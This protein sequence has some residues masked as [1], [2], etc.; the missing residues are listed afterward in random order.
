MSRNINQAIDNLIKKVLDKVD[1]PRIKEQK[2]TIY[3]DEDSKSWLKNLKTLQKLRLFP[4]FHSALGDYNND[5]Y[6]VL[7]NHQFEKIPCGLREENLNS[8]SWV[9]IIDDLN[10]Q[11]TDNDVSLLYEF[12]DSDFKINSDERKEIQYDLKLDNSGFSLQDVF[13]DIA[14]YKIDNQPS[15]YANTSSLSRLTGLILVES[16]K[17]YLLPYSTDVLVKFEVLFGSDQLKVSF[18]NILASY[19]AS[20]YKFCYLYLYRCIERVQP[21]LFFQDF[22][23]ELKSSSSQ[24]NKTLEEFCIDFYDKTKMQPKLDTSLEKLVQ[25]IINN[26]NPQ[27][28]QTTSG[29]LYNLRNQI[30]HLRPGQ[31]NSCIPGNY[32]DWNKL[33]EDMLQIIREIYT[34]HHSLMD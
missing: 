31:T 14:I 1:E 20:D 27:Y 3:G 10:L 33:I 15:K 19:A 6:L 5:K 24:F 17:Y 28:S 22:H 12:L 18:D 4:N 29:Y 9:A 16:K 32:D 21:L 23:N 2:Y 30:V 13:P 25:P 11:I 26:F 8:G 7:V 34:Q